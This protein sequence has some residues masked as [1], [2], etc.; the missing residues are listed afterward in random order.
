VDELVAAVGCSGLAALR[1]GTTQSSG[2]GTLRVLEVNPRGGGCPRV[3]RSPP[4][5]CLRP[6]QLPEITQH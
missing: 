2:H 1:P 3:G 6:A 4:R 5:T